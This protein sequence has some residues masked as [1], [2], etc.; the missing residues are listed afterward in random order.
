VIEPA[1]AP[2]VEPRTRQRVPFLG[3][4]AL[5]H[6][7]PSLPLVRALVQRGE[8]VDYFTT[9]RFAR[10][11]EA[12]GARFVPYPT[13]WEDRLARPAN[14]PDHVAGIAAAAAGLVPWLEP[15]LAGRRLLLFDG[16]ARWGWGA[17]RSLGIPCVSS[18]TTFALTPGMLRLLGADDGA[19][20][21]LATRGDL[22]VIHTSRELQPGGRYL[23]ESHL[24][25]GPL[26]GERP[27]LGPLVEPS[28]QRPLAYVS[29]GTIFNRDVDLLHRC[30]SALGAAGFEVIVSLGDPRAAVPS[31]WPHGTRV[32]SF[33][34]QGHVLGRASL[35]VSHGGLNGVS[36]AL[37]RGVP[38]ILIPHDVDQHLVARRVA[39]LGAAL[40]VERAD[41]TDDGLSAAVTRFA[42]SRPALEAAARRIAQSFADATPIGS[43]VDRVLALAADRAEAG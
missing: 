16:S 26:A 37:A 25:V 14:L 43:A 22:K 29:L 4:P 24:F 33:V 23:D 32:Y 13:E 30:A 27:D 8:P 7:I 39:G 21:V 18:V 1:A 28:G 10:L 34:A 2:S 42:V 35:F 17:A 12:A 5:G 15:R 40:L 36:E 3:F 6:T 19:A 11:V 38:L 9:P 31:G 20:D 41:A